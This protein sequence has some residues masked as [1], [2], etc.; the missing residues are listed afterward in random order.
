M[1]PWNTT[2]LGDGQDTF[3]IITRYFFITLA[4]S[5]ISLGKMFKAGSPSRDALV[6]VLEGRIKPCPENEHMME[7]LEALKKFL[8]M[9]LTSGNPDDKYITMQKIKCA[10]C[11]KQDPT[12]KLLVCGN[13]KFFRYCSRECQVADWKD[14]KVRCRE[15]ASH[16]KVKNLEA[17]VSRFMLENEPQMLEKLRKIYDGNDVVLDLDFSNQSEPELPPALRNPPQ[18]EVFPAD[19]FWNREKDKV[20]T[21]YNYLLFL[22]LKEYK[23]KFDS[24]MFYSGTWSLVLQGLGRRQ[25][26][27]L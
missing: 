3:K 20:S 4:S 8:D 27:V 7:I 13:C 1:G 19:V 6:D 12:Q 24:V 11:G 18:F 15:Y 10:K 5:S 17:I 9:G 21:W 26:P 16:A 22:E 14:H 23:Y 25:N 2:L